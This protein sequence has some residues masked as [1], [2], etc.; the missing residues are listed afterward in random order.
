[1]ALPET[2]IDIRFA[3][4]DQRRYGKYVLPG[5]LDIAQNVWQLEEGLYE[6]R[7]GYSA[8]DRFTTAEE[9]DEGPG[10]G[11]DDI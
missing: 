4:L 11:G 5:Q 10:G 1:M 3:A 8:M 2:P 6:K 9:A 7:D